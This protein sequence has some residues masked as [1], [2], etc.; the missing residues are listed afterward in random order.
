MSNDERLSLVAACGIDCGNCSL[1]LCRDNAALTDH[2]VQRGIA[3]EKLPCPGC[4]A[5]EGRCPVIGSPC[6]TY[7][8]VHLK[9]VDFCSECGDFPCPKLC[10]ASNRADV[11]PHNLKVFNLCTIERIGLEAFVKVS[12]DFE[13]L[14]FK[15]KMEIGKGPR[16]A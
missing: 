4:R 3:R 14:Y 9:E 6:E 16:P 15:G 11:L 2:L 12:A 13:R 10:P 1:Y 8:C 7:E 5:A